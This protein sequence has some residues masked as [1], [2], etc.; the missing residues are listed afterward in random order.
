MKIS[1]CEECGSKNVL[2]TGDLSGNIFAAT[3]QDCGWEWESV[4][5]KKLFKEMDDALKDFDRDSILL[6]KSRVKSVGYKN[7]M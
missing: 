6:T 4:E 2:I 7:K 5:F 1:K 3:C